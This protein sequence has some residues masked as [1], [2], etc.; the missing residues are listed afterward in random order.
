MTF[1]KA[2]LLW[3]NLNLGAAVPC[4]VE[5]DLSDDV[6]AL[7]TCDEQGR[8]TLPPADRARETDDG[9]IYNGF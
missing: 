8:A 5:L 7:G 3:F 6:G 4:D 2:F 9:G 1:V